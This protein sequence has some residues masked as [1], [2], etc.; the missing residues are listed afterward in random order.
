MWACQEL[1]PRL[2]FGG[3]ATFRSA[4][5]ICEGPRVWL[6]FT[7]LDYQRTIRLPAAG[8][9]NV[10]GFSFV[11][12]TSKAGRARFRTAA[13]LPRTPFRR[14]PNA[15]F[16]NGGHGEPAAWGEGGV[17]SHSPVCATKATTCFFPPSTESTAE[18]RAPAAA[19]TGVDLCHFN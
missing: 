6:M 12:A 4:S 14:D 7:R 2:V 9:A 17:P 13:H 11:T 8:E 3:E 19:P 10:T 1:Q 16:M 5:R 18:S 15:G